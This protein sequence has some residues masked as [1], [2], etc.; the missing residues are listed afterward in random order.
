MSVR[1]RKWRDPKTGVSN[2]SW[3]VDVNVQLPNGQNKRIRRVSPVQSRRGAQ[4]YERELRE[5]ILAG[6]THSTKEAKQCPTFDAF[7]VEFLANYAMANNKPSEVAAKE[8]IL[9]LH[10]TPFFGSMRLNKIRPRELERFKAKQ[11][12]THAAKTVNNQ[13]SVLG[14]LLRVA[15]EWELMEAAPP[16]KLLKVQR[17]KFDFLDFNEAEQL[18]A[19]CRGQLRVMVIT[20]LN[21]GMRSGELRALRWEDV[22]LKAGRVVVRRN[23]WRGQVGTPKSGKS[24]EIPLNETMLQ[25]LQQHRHLRGP[26]VFCRADG[27]MLGEE[28]ESKP[29]RA[30]CRRSGLREVGWHVLRHSFA[31]HLVMRGVPIKTVQELLGH[32]SIE[33]TRRYA[34]L[35]PEVRRDAVRV[36]DDLHRDG[37]LAAHENAE[38]VTRRS[39]K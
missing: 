17:P 21:T 18:V 14:R 15:A 8:R 38:S 11:L 2:M 1:R 20:N 31:S 4:A 36:L 19:A 9:E 35:S 22:D 7:A 6:T 13:L 34:H 30:A 33:M 16:I 25:A 26:W 29:L 28:Q 37:T 32:A 3:V 39:Q 24:R 27:D 10:L 23:V 5:A 12:Q